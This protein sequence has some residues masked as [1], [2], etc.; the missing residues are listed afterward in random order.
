VA[1]IFTIQ[2]ACAVNVSFLGVRVLTSLAVALFIAGGLVMAVAGTEPVKLNETSG[3]WVC[4]WRLLDLDGRAGLVDPHLG[5]QP[6][7]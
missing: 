2:N 7:C 5:G 4:L 1:V 6:G 3:G